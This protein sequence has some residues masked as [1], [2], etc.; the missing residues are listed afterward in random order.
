[1]CSKQL[2]KY[3]TL[4]SKR[5]LMTTGRTVFSFFNFSSD[6]AWV[7]IPRDIL[8]YKRPIYIA[9]QL[10]LSLEP[11]CMVKEVRLVISI[12]TVDGRHPKSQWVSLIHSFFYHLSNHCC[13]YWN[14]IRTEHHDSNNPLF[15]VSLAIQPSTT[16]SEARKFD[17]TDLTFFTVG[18]GWMSK[19]MECFS[20]DW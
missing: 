4:L 8:K 5:C 19:M 20:W 7:P 15:F 1:M 18:L 3:S 16:V 6:P 17:L 10:T 12:H 13:E 14:S 2:W 11:G 9:W